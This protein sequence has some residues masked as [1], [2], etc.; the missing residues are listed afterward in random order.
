MGNKYTLE[1]W[2]KIAKQF[3]YKGFYFKRK[4]QR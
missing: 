1:N 3:Y 2:N 4:E